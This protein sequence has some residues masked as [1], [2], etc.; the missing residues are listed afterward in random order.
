MW[1]RLRTLCDFQGRRFQ[2]S[3]SPNPLA[4][5]R[6][7]RKSWSIPHASVLLFGKNV[8]LSTP[9]TGSSRCR[10]RRKTIRLNQT[11]RRPLEMV[12]EGLL[13]GEAE[14]SQVRESGH[15]LNSFRRRRCCKAPTRQLKCQSF[16][17]TWWTQQAQTRLGKQKGFVRLVANQTLRAIAF[18]CKSASH[19]LGVLNKRARRF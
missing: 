16:T 17:G 8:L 19:L 1:H 12:P 3:T 18:S 15:R 7:G 2:E 10:S 5:S 4:L 11:Y 6:Q 14:A 13:A 9:L